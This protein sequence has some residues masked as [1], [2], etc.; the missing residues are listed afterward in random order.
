MANPVA[1]PEVAGRQIRWS[2][3]GRV[4]AVVAAAIAGIVS[5]P[6]LLGSDAPPPVPP[7]VGI[8]PAPV[9]A[10]PAPVEAP[11]PPPP[12]PKPKRRQSAHRVV[13]H[14]PPARR[15]HHD[16]PPDTTRPGPA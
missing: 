16:E 5:L 11:T 7:D 14:R 4:A 8:T 9:A 3:V 15:R 1:H 2:S 10:T 6:A 12:A 13:H